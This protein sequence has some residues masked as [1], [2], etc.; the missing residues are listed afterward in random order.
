MIDPLSLEVVGTAVTAAAGSAGSEA[1]RQAWTSL[2]SLVRRA[3]GRGSDEEPAV[4]G[5]PLDP[6]DEEQIRSLTALVFGRAYQDQEFAEAFA[7]WRRSNEAVLGAS[8]VTV[9]NTVTG[10]AR[11]QNLVQGQNITWNAK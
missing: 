8:S 1:G 7:E 6:G 11:V 9:R 4:S 3:F 2:A 10:G 5:L